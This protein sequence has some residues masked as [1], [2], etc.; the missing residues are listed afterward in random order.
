MFQCDWNAIEAM[1]HGGTI[2][3]SVRQNIDSALIAVEDTGLRIPAEVR[4]HLFEPFVTGG[5]PEGL[6]LGLAPTRCFMPRFANPG[7]P[8]GNDLCRH[9]ARHQQANVRD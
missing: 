2:D 4:D 9:F 1:L 8:D 7:P 5:K 3:I 6:G